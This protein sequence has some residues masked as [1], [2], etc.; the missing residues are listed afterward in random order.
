M[1]S[2][3][4]LGCFQ[5]MSYVNSVAIG[6]IL[7][8]NWVPH[9]CVVTSLETH[10]SSNGYFVIT[11]PTTQA[12]SLHLTFPFPSPKPTTVTPQPSR[13]I[14]FM[15]LYACQFFRFNFFILIL[16]GFFFYYLFRIRISYKLIFLFFV[17]VEHILSDLGGPNLF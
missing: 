8:Y 13:I 11:F 14:N 5:V 1:N 3:T 6:I 17:F 12:S 16:E 7:E 2:E 15:G 4:A 9:Q 10:R